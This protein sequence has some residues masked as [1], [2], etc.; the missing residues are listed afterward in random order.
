MNTKYAYMLCTLVLTVGCSLRNEK[1]TVEGTISD[2]ADSMLYLE[3][4]TLG[5]GVQKIDS[6]RLDTSGHFRLRG[7]RPENPEFYR[8]RI[9]GEGINL[10]I[11]SSETVRVKA[12]LS[13][14]SFGYQ[15]EGSGSCDTIRLL[16]LKMAQL[17]RDV[18]QTANNRSLTLEERDSKI[19]QMITR[20]KSEV[21]TDFIQHN[22]AGAASYFACFQMLWGQRLFDPM[23][24]RDDLKW[25]RAVAN[26]WN[27]NYPEAQRTENLANIVAQGRRNQAP[28]RQITLDLDDERVSELGIID[29][30]FPDIQGR[31]ITLSSL[32][33]KVVLLDFTAYSLR[34]SSE[35]M[36]EMRR[37]YDKFHSRGFEIYQVSVDPDRH[38]WT[39]CCENLPWTCVYCDEGVNADMLTLYQV[40]Q[41]PCYFL[42]DRNCD[43]S[44][45]QENIPNLERAIEALL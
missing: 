41:L 3:Q 20:Y 37:L 45:R 27:E 24:D 43:L 38:V 32:R 35:R 13:N 25:I 39:Q 16:C 21:K 9:G 5:N 42:I 6:A 4:I 7:N 19:Q 14:L 44:A 8:L 26:A 34:G 40:S 2:A 30:T 1:F 36:L 15:I 31:E 29:M 10:A 22:L 18:R 23:N 17:E 11:D 33:G 12:T 28:P